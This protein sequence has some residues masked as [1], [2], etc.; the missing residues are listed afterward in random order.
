MTLFARMTGRERLTLDELR[1]LRYLAE[2]GWSELKKERGIDMPYSPPPITRRAVDAIMGAITKIDR[3]VM[4]T[5]ARM[6]P[7]ERATEPPF[8]IRSETFAE[9]IMESSGRNSRPLRV[10][11]DEQSEPL[12]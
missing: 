2:R 4:E 10:E 3:S 5:E 12:N 1:A 11:I 8:V 6:D 9:A 7:E